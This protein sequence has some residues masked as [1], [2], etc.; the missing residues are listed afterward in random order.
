MNYT[1]FLEF[2]LENFSETIGYVAQGKINIRT[3]RDNT[4]EMWFVDGVVI[5]R[6]FI[7]DV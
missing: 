1:E 6:K 7:Q 2:V 5:K 3:H 4:G